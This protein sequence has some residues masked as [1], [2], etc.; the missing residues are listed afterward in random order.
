M[1]YSSTLEP[2]DDIPFDANVA[3]CVQSAAVMTGA[4]FSMS[5][6]GYH[7]S[8]IAAMVFAILA[9]CAFV[10][11]GPLLVHDA[12]VVK[13]LAVASAAAS[14]SLAMALSRIALRSEYVSAVRS[15]FSS[16]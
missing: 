9:I 7:A 11:V 14:F 3:T 16:T 12:G 13:V 8:V 2:P 1:K 6:R 15:V 4:P 10:K 5:S